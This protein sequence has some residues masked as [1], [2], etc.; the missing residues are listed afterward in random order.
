MVLVKLLIIFAIIMF[1]VQK[2]KPMSLAIVVGSIATWALYQLPF[3][4]VAVAAINGLTALS[5]LQLVLVM[6]LITFIQRMMEARGAVSLMRTG[7]GG[8]FN[9]RWV[10]CAAAPA[11]IGLLPSPNA[12]MIAGEVVKGTTDGII[13][14]EDQAVTTTFFRHISEA[15]LPTYGFILIALQIAEISVS[16]FVIAML[17]MVVVLL[18]LGC[19]FLLRGKVPMSTGETM[20]RSNSKKHALD[21][22][23]GIWPIAAVITL[24]VGFEFQIYTS[25]AITIAAYYVVNKFKFSEIMPFFLSAFESKIVFNTLA[26][27]TFKELLTATGAMEALPAFFSQFP[28]PSFLIF[29]LIFLFGTLVAGTTATVVLCLPLAMATVPNAGLPLVVLL[30]SISYVAMQVSPTHICLTITAEYFNVKLN[31]IIKRTIPIIVSF[32]IISILYYLAWTTL[33]V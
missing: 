9:N 32:T 7:L 11:V 8:L 18:A 30:M 10:N 16:S 17:P 25:A 27:M 2:G 31:D 4:Q 24:V 23:K 29:V 33:F 1:I 12:V 21:L 26:V 5:T 6:Y 19:F 20:D 3:N 15:F 28:I 14:K 13:P 22:L